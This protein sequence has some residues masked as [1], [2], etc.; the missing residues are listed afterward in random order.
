M[1]N[2]NEHEYTNRYKTIFD[3]PEDTYTDEEVDNE[4]ITDHKRG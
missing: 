3:H 2:T 1:I 4:P